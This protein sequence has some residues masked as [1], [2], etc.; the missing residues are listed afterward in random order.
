M[1]NYFL[2]SNLVRSRKVGV[3]ARVDKALL[4]HGHRNAGEPENKSKDG[5]G[6]W[7]WKS[8]SASSGL[9]DRTPSSHRGNSCERESMS[10]RKLATERSNEPNVQWTALGSV[11][12]KCLVEY[13]RKPLDLVSPMML[14]TWAGW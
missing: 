8:R 6:R 4:D 7:H 5:G 2:V 11:R 14:E 12:Y 13:Q 3:I 9:C 10:A 1:V